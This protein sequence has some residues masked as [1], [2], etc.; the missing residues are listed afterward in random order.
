MCYN[1]SLELE[2]QLLRRHEERNKFKANVIYTN[3]ALRLT[4]F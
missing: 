3:I 2:P 1:P 4:F